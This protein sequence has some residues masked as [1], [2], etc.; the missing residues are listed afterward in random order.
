[1]KKNSVATNGNHLAA[2]L[3]SM[4]RCVMLLFVRS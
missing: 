2:M 4:F 1:M 3:A